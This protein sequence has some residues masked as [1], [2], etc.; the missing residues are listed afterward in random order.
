MLARRQ[1]RRSPRFPENGYS[2]KHQ[3]NFSQGKSKRTYLG[4]DCQAKKTL[5]KLC[6]L[7]ESYFVAPHEQDQYS[8]ETITRAISTCTLRTL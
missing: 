4:L 1:P 3:H 6:L 7:E 2:I 8:G 5:M